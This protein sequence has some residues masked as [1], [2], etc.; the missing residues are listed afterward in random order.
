MSR[1]SP[2]R[3]RQL[4]ACLDEAL[5]LPPAGRA[6]WLA[7]LR[8]RDADLAAELEALLAD[9][10]VLD[11]QRFLDSG[12]GSLLLPSMHAGQQVGAYALVAPIGEGGMGSV[13]LAE[14]HDGRFDRRAAVKFLSVALGERGRERFTREGR[15]LA[16]LSHPHIA[17][18]VDAGVTSAGQPYLVLEHIEGETIDRYCDAHALSVDARVRLVLDVLSAVSH[19]HANLIVHRDLKP[20][21]VLVTGDGQAKLLDFGIAKLLGDDRGAAGSTLTRE[22]GQAFT[23]QY[24]APEQLT[25][26]VITTATDVYALGVLLY[27]ILTGQHPAGPGPF[28]TASLV[29][30]IVESDPPGLSEVVLRGPGDQAALSRQAALRDGATPGKLSHQLSGDLE[31]IVG[32][33]MKK[34]PSGRYGSVD[35]LADDLSRYLRRQ[36]ISARPDTLA[37]RAAKF[38]RRNRAATALAG[39]ALLAVVGGV[40]GTLVQAYRA[41]VQRDFALRE[42]SRAEAVNDLNQFVLSDAAPSGKPFTVDDLLARAEHVVVRQHGDP[43]TRVD[44]LVSIGRQYTVQEEYTKARALLESAYSLAQTVPDLS[45][46]AEAACSLAQVLSNVGD[47]TRAETLYQQGLDSLP[48]TSPYVLDRFFCLERGAEIA[49]NRATP[50]LALARAEAAE[51]ALHRAPLSSELLD[52]QSLIALAGAYRDAGRL[53]ESADNFRQAADKLADLGR[54]DTAEAATVFN[55]WGVTLTFAGRPLDAEKILRRALDISRDNASDDAVSAMP[56]VNYAR[57]LGNLDR[58]QEA[59]AYAARGYAKAQRSGNHVAADQALLLQ[60]SI[61]L[62][63]GDPGSAAQRLADVDPDLRRLPPGHIAH[64]SLSSL[65]ALL[66]QARGDLP[67]ALALANESVRIADAAVRQSGAGGYYLESYLLRRADIELRSGRTAD[68]IAD[69]SRVISGLSDPAQRS[70]YAGEAYLVLGR[71]LQ[72]EGR[73]SEATSAFRQ[74]LVN[75]QEALGP[76]NPSTLAARRLAGA[77]APR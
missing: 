36:P 1:P 34:H 51:A 21:N 9:R 77:D 47:L 35:A 24:A 67:S 73:T 55:N 52:T 75:F 41:R 3:W 16:R 22:G 5:D 70:S 40:S 42:L 13:W 69:A 15:I 71:A 46:R 48:D 68:V 14:R 37:Y 8:A 6:A 44:L 65:K 45:T 57:A 19:A 7:A 20:S 74:A 58:A 72:A 53:G 12:P 62:K 60:A 4:S 38:V 43:R 17:Q 29:K 2:H 50:R 66:A 32:K 30:S 23:P 26:G 61:D 25:G 64:A 33:A 39:L 10:D 63:L 31:T 11:R 56:L 18:L 27:E 54:D 76:D 28:S 59:Q 49:T